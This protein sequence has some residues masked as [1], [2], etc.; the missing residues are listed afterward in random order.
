MDFRKKWL[1]KDDFSIVRVDSLPPDLVKDQAKKYLGP[2]YPMLPKNFGVDQQKIEK[3][4][5]LKMRLSGQY[6]LCLGVLYNEDLIGWTEGWQD[7]IEQDSFFMGASLVVPAFQKR[8]L[9]SELVKKVFEI[10]KEDGFQSISSLHVMT[11]NPVLIAKLKLG[12]HLNGFEI[13]TRYGA[14]ARLIYH[15]NEIKKRALKFR[16]G[17]INETQILEALKR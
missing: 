7:S 6:K 3:L 9:Y 15:H 14:L 13:N 17:A 11:N 10:T 2:E 5:E 1:I 8:G 12:F 16:A 4:N